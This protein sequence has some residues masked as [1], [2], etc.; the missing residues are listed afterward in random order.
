MK[1]RYALRN[2]MPYKLSIRARKRENS[3]TTATKF[4]KIFLRVNKMRTQSYLL[5][6]YLVNT[7]ANMELMS[8]KLQSDEKSELYTTSIAAQSYLDNFDIVSAAS[9][10]ERCWEEKRQIAELDLITLAQKIQSQL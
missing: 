10:V 7:F 6:A 8:A 1:N 2:C 5:S 4:L 3:A 9:L